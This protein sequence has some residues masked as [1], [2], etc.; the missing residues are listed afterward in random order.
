MTAYFYTF[1]NINMLMVSIFQFDSPFCY[2]IYDE[3]LKLN[4]IVLGLEVNYCSD[5]P[6]QEL[7]LVSS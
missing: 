4:S 6:M 5:F 7:Q 1:N 2:I 3:N